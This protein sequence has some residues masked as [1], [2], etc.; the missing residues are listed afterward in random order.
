MSS[1]DVFR[2]P[3]NYLTG[4]DLDRFEAGASS[5]MRPSRW[6]SREEDYKAALAEGRVKRAARLARLSWTHEEKAIWEVYVLHP[7][8]HSQII[9]ECFA[10]LPRAVRH[11]LQKLRADVARASEG[12][13][14]IAADVDV[15]Q[16]TPPQRRPKPRTRRVT[17]SESLCRIRLPGHERELHWLRGAW[18]DLMDHTCRSN[19]TRRTMTKDEADGKHRLGDSVMRELVTEA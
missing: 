4:L 8:D 3:R 14:S 2:T 16:G 5:T 7:R 11:I 1:D 13:E 12:I 18:I 10:I 6:N 15:V 17:R 19:P 9:M